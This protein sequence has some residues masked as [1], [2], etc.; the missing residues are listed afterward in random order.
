MRSFGWF[1]IGYMVVGV[2]LNYAITFTLIGIAFVKDKRRRDKQ[3]KE[4]EK[5][6]NEYPTDGECVTAIDEVFDEARDR[7]EYMFEPGN[8]KRALIKAW[9][10][11]TL[12]LW[13]VTIPN[14][15]IQVWNA[16]K[17]ADDE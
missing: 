7:A 10:V 8:P 15:I 16:I 5:P 9:I 1:I 12:I 17:S 6:N 4:D 11:G 2:I 14:G 3:L 13:P